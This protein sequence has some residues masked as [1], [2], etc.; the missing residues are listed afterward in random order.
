MRVSPAMADESKVRWAPQLQ[1]RGGR[2]MP[3]PVPRRFGMPRQA[4]P[5]L[6]LPRLPRLVVALGQVFV[7]AVVVDA[8]LA[9]WFVRSTGIAS[10]SRASAYETFALPGEKATASR[11]HSDALD[12]SDPR[13]VPSDKSE[14]T[15]SRDSE[16]TNSE[17]DVNKSQDAP[18]VD[19]ARPPAIDSA[20]SDSGKET[21]VESDSKQKP[22]EVLP[23]RSD[24]EESA[25]PG[26]CAQ[27][28]KEPR[29]WT[30]TPGT[31]QERKRCSRRTDAGECYDGSPITFFSQH[32]QGM[33]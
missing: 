27:L 1:A 8:L 19:S 18:A 29:P 2:G 17:T 7:F 26:W 3:G 13:D 28:A 24:W 12:E 4:K 33:R 10:T 20:D 31:P 6:T 32:H 25:P 23:R 14:A 5:R 22:W 9:R 21:V 16:D 30:A 15:D 11:E